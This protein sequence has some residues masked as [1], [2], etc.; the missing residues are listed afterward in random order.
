MRR[1]G[2]CLIFPVLTACSGGY[3]KSLNDANKTI[4][5]AEMNLKKAANQSLFRDTPLVKVSEDIYLGNKGIN[6]YHGSPLPGKFE[7]STGVTLRT[8]FP[9][10]LDN[11]ISL[12][13]E[14]TNIP[15]E[16]RFNRQSVGKAPTLAGEVAEKLD[17]AVGAI[18]ADS[19]FEVVTNSASGD[20]QMKVD[21]T[22]P[23]S[24]FLNRVALN[25]D[26]F[27][28]YEDGRLL[29]STEETKK[30]NISVLPGTYTTKN[31]VSSDSNNS[32]SG[33][34][35][36]GGGSDSSSNS[37]QLDINVSLD[38]WKDIEE[39]LKL[40]IGDTGSYTI[41][42]STSS[43]IVRTSASNMKR[44]SD[45]IEK[46]NNQLERQV[47]IDV[48]VYSVSTSDVSNLSLSLQALLT[49]N[50]GVL[51]SV[52]SDF[53]AA[54]GTPTITGFLNGDGDKNNQVLLNLL[55]SAGKVSMV[56]SAA[57]TTMS[58]QPVPLKVGND[59]TYVSEIGTV[60]GQ[61]ATTSSV[62]T[63]SVTTGF[64]MNL[65]PQI[66]DDG[67]IMMQY[68]IT[69]S[70][71]VGRNNGFEQVSVNGT[72]IQLPNVDST[73]FIQS[74]IL[75]N[76]NTLVLAGYEQK[77]SEAV[78]EGLGTPEFKLFGGARNGLN[79]REI[80]IICITPRII[81]INGSQISG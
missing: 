5:Q 13:H 60:I 54:S 11:I 39:S 47:T 55:A 25:Y 10:G 36:G 78:D 2:L 52:S 8:G 49:N 18:P 51:G 28:T 65:L 35:S 17:K 45:Y 27:W 81:D 41:S 74:S 4:E 22:G 71:L 19:A 67:K 75:K 30:F 48:A 70:S 44:V 63:S 37:S 42:T 66:A 12:L 14:A 64:L 79:N 9:V 23:L 46:L 31:T 16:K 7:T 69:L 50:G 68:G 59:R 72:I 34:G 57:V 6:S 32:S 15:I 3:Q 62:S 58:G 29:F 77:R 56:T 61:T 43:V 73:T 38:V 53:A 24:D 33:S 26:L 40:I 1:F 21:Y 20:M 76:G 80:K